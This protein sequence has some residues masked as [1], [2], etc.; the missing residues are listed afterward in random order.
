[1]KYLELCS[2]IGGMRS[3][4][5]AANWKCQFS[6]DNSEDAVKVHRLANG[7][8]SLIDIHDLSV[9]DLPN[10]DA[11]VAGFPC[12]P[13]SSSGNRKGFK[14]KSGNVFDSLLALLNAK[15]PKIVIL[16]NVEGLLSNK[17]GHT[18]ATILSKLTKLN[19]S[20]D[21]LLL[22]LKWFG[23]PQTRPRLFIVCSNR[24][25]FSNK[26]DEIFKNLNIS[27]DLQGNIFLPLLDEFK[28]VTKEKSKGTLKSL[29][30]ELTPRIG[31]PHNKFLPFGYFGSAHGDKFISHNIK[32]VQHYEQSLSLGNVVCPNFIYKDRVRSGRYY[33]RGGPTH[34]HLRQNDLSHCVGTSLGG[35]PLFAVNLNY[36]K[37]SCDRDSFLEHSNWH[38]E[39]DGLI[40]MRL[41]PERSIRLFGPNTEH[42]EYALSNWSA[43]ATRKYKLVGNMVSPI[44]ALNLAKIIDD[45]LRSVS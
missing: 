9:N 29:V 11:W 2:G 33:A 6:V 24:S 16:E 34:L 38:R 42:L 19:Y 7:E 32:S 18:F 10:V 1:M 25:D 41:S 22:N 21:W 17:S 8:C 37:K 45:Q 13:F 20:V 28:I 5:D 3:G 40:V 36:C 15:L 23:I 4:L 44:C 43:G 31:K 30:K 14:H 27:K 35:A 12:Q 26:G 39:Q